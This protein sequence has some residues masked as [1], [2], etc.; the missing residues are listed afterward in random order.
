LHQTG[1]SN[2]WQSAERL[3]ALF[4][5]VAD[6]SDSDSEQ[7]IWSPA[8]KPVHSVQRRIKGVLT[9]VQVTDLQHW[10]LQFAYAR[11]SI[12]HDGVVPSLDYRSPSP[13]SAYDG[14]M[15]FTA[16]FL[17]R[18]I[19]KVSLGPL[20]YPDLWRSAVWR[21]VKTAMEEWERKAA[22]GQENQP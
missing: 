16:E 10:F 12:I 4:E 13:P 15:V 7:L 6:T 22:G 17:I 1:T 18:A 11:N 5:G 20:G 21:A 3:R 2:S 9:P 8:E 19:I 14:H